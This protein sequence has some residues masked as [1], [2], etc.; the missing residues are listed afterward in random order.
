MIMII[1]NKFVNMLLFIA[2]CVN[3]SAQSVF[4]WEN[5]VVFRVNNEPA[6]A[7]LIPYTDLASA[8][9]FNLGRSNLYRSLNGVWKF[10]YLKNPSETP[11]E[12]YAPAFQD[13]SWDKIEVPGNWQ[14]Q[15]KYDPPV[16]S[17]IKHPFKADPPRVPHDYDPT[18]LYRT[19]FKIP[20]SWKGNQVF[21]HFAGIQSAGTV[22][23]NGRKVGYSEDA[24]TPAEYNITDFLKPGENNLAV[25]VLNW[26]DGSYLEDQDFWRL[27]G[28]YRD[29]FLYAT[30]PQHIRDYQ[31]MTELDDQYRD[32]VLK[33]KVSLKPEFDTHRHFLGS[34]E[35]L[36]D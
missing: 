31:V 27:S 8:T 35:I 19:S 5:P 29:V 25:Q 21:L 23:L 26:S 11:V 24:M 17:N 22:Y 34:H 16:F 12:F 36:S 18:G 28:I 3:L 15:G 14:L 32:A 7:S 20:E 2:L 6:H 9:T 10:K 13:A 1:K 33:L 4:D 30:P